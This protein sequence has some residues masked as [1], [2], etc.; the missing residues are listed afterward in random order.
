MP[1]VAEQDQLAQAHISGQA[2]LR[3]FAAAS[4]AGA[5]TVLPGHDEANVPAFLNAVVP[6]V[7]A[8]QRASVTLTEAYLARAI[9]RQPVGVNVDRLVGAAVRNGTPPT[10]VYRRP[11]VT[12]WSALKDGKPHQDAVQAGLTRATTAAETD[13]QLSMRQTLTA[14]GE[15]NA[16]IL[17][18][19]RIPDPGACP[20][21]LLV[22]GQRYRT[23]QLMPIHPHCG[24][25]VGVITTENRHEFTGNP[26]NDLSVTAGGVDAAVVEHGEL[27]PLLVDG[28]QN[29]TSEAEIAALAH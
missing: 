27:G 28:T 16:L 10:E 3:S 4:V 2:Q 6:V 13:V 17:G 25:G 9:G 11:F 24:C 1:T 15:A 21:C 18:Y 29:F 22:A 20:F 14:V 5:W 19:R 8:A 26:K 12:V 7:A 23:D